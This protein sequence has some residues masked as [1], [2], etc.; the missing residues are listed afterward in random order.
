MIASVETVLGPGANAETQLEK[1]WP[2]F[3]SSP[4]PQSVRESPVVEARINHGKWI[5]D[6]PA[7]SCPGAELVVVSDPRFFCMSCDNRDFDGQWLR[8]Q[9][10]AEW[11]Q[12]SRILGDRPWPTIQHWSPG[13]T[14]S[15]LLDENRSLGRAIDKPN[16]VDLG[17]I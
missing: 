4:M 7:E 17:R 8:V 10:P 16:V 9:L 14:V 6:C 12:I 15:D 13:E 3:G 11:D 5:A 2:R 1:F